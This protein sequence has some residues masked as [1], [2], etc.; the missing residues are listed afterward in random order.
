MAKG[1]L[2]DMTRCIG[3]RGCQIACKQWNQRSAGKTEMNGNFTNPPQLNADTFTNVNYVEG[4][5]GGQPVWSFVKNQ[6][7][8]CKNPACASVCPVSALKKTPE[9]PV[10]YTF[11]RC[12]GC[13]Y[14]M[15]ACPFY[16]PKYEWTNVQP[17]VRKC[18][19]CAD[20]LQANL[21]PAC[22]KACPTQSMLFG[23]RDEIKAEAEK[24][25]RDHPGKYVNY[26]YG[27]DEA[28]GTSW[29]YISGVPFEQLGFNMNV[30]RSDLPDLTWAYITKI[31]KVIGVV[32]V[33]G[34]VLWAITRRQQANAHPDEKGKEE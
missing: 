2:V 19:F 20:R 25:L 30:P 6:C 3:C 9:G 12:I 13:R 33:A 22:V 8:H 34:P 31:P 4:E 27:K 1:V 15:I 23:E 10:T 21:A 32:L 24:R 16:V 26:I 11:E 5:N 17:W 28:G 29:L 7:L 14:C 18:T